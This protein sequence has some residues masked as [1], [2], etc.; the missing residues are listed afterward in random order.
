MG[1]SLRKAER[2]AL[3]AFLA[4]QRRIVAREMDDLAEENELMRR[5][6]AE[7]KQREALKFR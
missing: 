6:L 1:A 5:Q 2:D 7:I 4:V 3:N